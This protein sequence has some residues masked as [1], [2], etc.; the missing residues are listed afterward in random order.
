MIDEKVLERVR[1]LLAKAEATSFPAEAEA[2]TAKAQE[3][4]TR[5]AIDRI[6]IDQGG[7][8]GPGDHRIVLEPPYAKAKFHLLAVVGE[9]N[10]CRVIGRR[11]FGSA[12]VIGFPADL[13]AV[14]VLFTSLLV[15]ATTAMLAKGA[16]HD[17]VGRSRTRSF[18]SAF[19]FAFAFRVG[20][21]LQDVT[22]EAT[23][24][25]AGEHESLLPVLASREDAI[26]RFVEETFGPLRATRVSISNGDGFAAGTA[27]ADAAD[28][29]GP[30]RVTQKT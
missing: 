25:A 1:G 24:T 12:T 21:R 29:G 3:L 7:T 16:H 19:L 28:L 8:A 13:E 9:A 10:R 26:D 2:F 30:A 11:G 15:Q 6:L 22:R 5:H 4:M 20:Q 18:R 23:A 17:P 27:A 14:E